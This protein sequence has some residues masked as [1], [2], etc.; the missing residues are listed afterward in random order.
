MIILDTTI[1]I[2]AVPFVARG[3]PV[4]ALVQARYQG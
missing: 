4:G 1:V 3:T 2:V